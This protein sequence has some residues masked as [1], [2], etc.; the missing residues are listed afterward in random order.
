M[1]ATLP[2]ENNAYFFLQNEINGEDFTQILPKFFSGILLELILEG[3]KD[4]NSTFS[5]EKVESS[6]KGMVV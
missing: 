3:Y 5:S 4:S 1:L 2:W 6:R